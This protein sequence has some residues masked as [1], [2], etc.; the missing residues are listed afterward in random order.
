MYASFHREHFP[1][2]HLFRNAAAA[3]GAA[4]MFSWFALLV[5]EM[6]RSG[7]WVPNIHSLNQALA[8]AVIF[9]SYAIG[10]R[11]EL[12][13]AALA[14]AGTALFFAIGMAGT[15]VW[16]QLPVAWF[17]APG[18]LYLLAW[19]CGDRRQVHSRSS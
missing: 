10:W 8:L 19:I 11:H 3:S 15:G 16:P 7:D 5:I 1:V 14:I 6:I 18:V 12:V 4:L 17:A 2:A 13:G 9:A